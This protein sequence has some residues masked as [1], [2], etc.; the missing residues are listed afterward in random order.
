MRRRDS[1]QWRN[2]RADAARV[3]PGIRMGMEL[4]DA[5]AQTGTRLASEQAK[6]RAELADFRLCD[7]LGCAADW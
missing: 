4:Q 6:K 5:L 2:L 1:G 7:A 3:T